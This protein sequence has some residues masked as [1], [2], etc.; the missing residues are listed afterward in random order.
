MELPAADVEHL[1]GV[2]VRRGVVAAKHLSFVGEPFVAA[3]GV[4]VEI[5]LFEPR[6]H[7][8][9]LVHVLGGRHEA[10]VG[11]LVGIGEFVQE[12]SRI[13]STSTFENSGT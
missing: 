13:G 9:E 1:I 10:D 11:V 4:N 2:D 12:S 6:T 7:L 5:T 3:A 8:L